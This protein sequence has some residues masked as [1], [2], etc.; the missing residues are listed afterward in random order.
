MVGREGKGQQSLMGMHWNFKIER[1]KFEFQ[2][3]ILGEWLWECPITFLIVHFL[4]CNAYV[5]EAFREVNELM[6]CEIVL[7][8]TKHFWSLFF[9]GFLLPCVHHSAIALPRLYCNL[10]VYICLP[11][12]WVFFRAKIFVL[13]IFGHQDLT[14]W[15]SINVWWMCE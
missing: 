12:D 13:F 8:V 4:A 7:W 11:L 14:H 5:T 3:S 2:H 10:F 15:Y 6:D 9:S 1:R